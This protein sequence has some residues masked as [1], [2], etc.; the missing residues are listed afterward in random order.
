MVSY[1]ETRL[2]FLYWSCI[3]KSW[4]TLC[5]FHK[6]LQVENCVIYQLKHFYFFPFPIWICF[7]LFLFHEPPTVLII[8]YFLDMILESVCQPSSISLC[9]YVWLTL[10]YTVLSSDRA[11]VW[12]WC[13][14]NVGL[15]S[16][17]WSVH[18]ELVE[19]TSEATEPWVFFIERHFN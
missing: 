10:L 6:I 17:F 16:F 14:I 12:L 13:W 3:P 11:S 1:K 8:L 2:F 15:T 4:L 9:V 7:I 18:V 19:F 5:K